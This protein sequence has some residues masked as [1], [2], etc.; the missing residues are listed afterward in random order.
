MNSWL[1]EPEW[2]AVFA[3]FGTSETLAFSC[4]SSTQLSIARIY[5]GASV[6]GERYT[7][8]PQTDELIRDDVLKFVS[9]AR[10]EAMKARAALDELAE[11]DCQLHL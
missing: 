1:T 7:Y 8:F 9:K 5:G 4:V 2:D 10:K 6:N 11:V 3:K